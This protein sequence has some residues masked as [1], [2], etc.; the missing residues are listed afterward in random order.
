MNV[1][2]ALAAAA[3]RVRRRCAAARHPPGPAHL[4]DELLPLPR[5]PQRGR[6]QRRQRHRRLLPQ[7]AR[8]EDARRLRR[9]ASATP[10]EPRPTSSAR[11]SRIGVIA[12][13]GD[14]RDAGH[15]RARRRSPPSTS[16]WSSCARTSTCAAASAARRPRSSP[17]ACGTAMAEGARCK[18]VEIVLDEIEAVRH[19]MARANRRRPRR[20]LRRQARGRSWPSSRTGPPGARPAPI[21]SDDPPLSTADC[22]PGPPRPRATTPEDQRDAGSSGLAVERAHLVAQRLGAVDRGALLLQP[23]VDLVA[24][25][26]AH[27]RRPRRPG[28]P[29]PTSAA[30]QPARSGTPARSVTPTARA[31][32][33]ISASSP[34]PSA[35]AEVVLLVPDDDVVGAARRRARRAARARRRCG[36]RRCRAPRGRGRRAARSP[37]ITSSRASRPASLCARSM[38]TVT[39]A[40]GRR[41]VHPARVVLGAGPERAQALDDAARRRCRSPAQPRRRPAR[42]RR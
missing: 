42:S 32:S 8:H 12:T 20:G 7:R 38:T 23:R 16:T 34:R 35:A 13:A 2:N 1:Q 17:R 26:V 19:A 9:P 18:Q 39:P 36:P 31:P 30:R 41:D 27:H 24:L 40:V 28:A 22:Q 6:G 11:P 33:R 10:L 21:G 29:A 15:A 37:C 4:L 3:A 25:G 14:R 5:P